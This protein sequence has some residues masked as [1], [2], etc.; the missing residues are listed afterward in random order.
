MPFK[1]N[2]SYQISIENMDIGVEHIPG[3]VPADTE[4]A[5]QARRKAWDALI[6]AGEGTCIPDQKIHVFVTGN[7]RCICK[8]RKESA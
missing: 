3:S 7:G 1:A 4:L 6:A 5:E 8:A 2:K